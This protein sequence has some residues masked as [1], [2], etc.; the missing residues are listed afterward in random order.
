MDIKQQ[1]ALAKMLREKTGLPLMVCKK[2]LVKNDFN[3]NKSLEDSKN[4]DLTDEIIYINNY[5][6]KEIK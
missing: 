3:W 4:V 2:V 1:V 5:I 6:N